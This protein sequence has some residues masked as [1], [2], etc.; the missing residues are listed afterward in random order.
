MTAI[1]NFNRVW[2]L[3]QRY[4]VEDRNRVLYFWVFF[5]IFFMFFRNNSAAVGLTIVVAGIAFCGRFFREIHSPT[6]GLNYFMIPATQAE[7]TAVSIFLTTVYFFGM[8]LAMYT[9]GNLAGTFINNTLANIPFLSSGLDLFSQKP[10]RWCLL[11]APNADMIANGVNT[12]F[13][14]NPY[15]WT[16][17]KA[18]LFI[19]A[20]FTLGSLYFKRSPV[21]KTILTLFI[22]GTVNGIVL[23][24]GVVFALRIN[25]NFDIFTLSGPSVNINFDGKDIPGFIPYLL[26]PYLWILGYFKLTEKEL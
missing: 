21:F 5:F 9:I 7:K 1:F 6:S 13:V 26:I 12:N 14:G 20:I 23:L 17:F 11:E 8:M 22:G 15:V 16:F 19:Q 18:Y 4:F 2:W 3:L 24:L 25:G 10:L